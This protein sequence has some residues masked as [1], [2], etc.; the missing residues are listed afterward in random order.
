MK[1]YKPKNVFISGV[2]RK[3]T[4][5]DL[6]PSGYVENIRIILGKQAKNTRGNALEISKW[7]KQNDISEILLITSDYH[8]PRSITELKLV[9]DFLKIYPYAV[10]SDVTFMFIGKC[11]KELHKIVYVYIRNFAERAGVGI[12]Y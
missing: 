7:A 11:I 3:T 10:K 12:C 2:H 4:L 5:R 9:G 6:L 8:I 1:S